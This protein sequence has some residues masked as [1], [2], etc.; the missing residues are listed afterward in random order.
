ME[1]SYEDF[2][3]A[4]PSG[5]T[6]D[7]EVYD[8]V[9][10]YFDSRIFLLRGILTESLFRRIEDPESEAGGNDYNRLVR[11]NLHAVG[12]VC[13]SAYYL[14]IP[15]LDLVLT[16]TGFGVVSNQNVAPASADRVA[17]LRRQVHIDEMNHLDE[18]I[19]LARPVINWPVST[20]DRY[21]FSS[22][23]W[24][25]EQLRI[26]G[27]AEPTR[28]DLA[29]NR[30]A[31]E[32]AARYIGET[33]SPELH[34]ALIK[35]EASA[36]ATVPQATLIAMWRSATADYIRCESGSPSAAHI[37]LRDS[38]RRMLRYVEE[39]LEAFPEYRDS[40]TYQANHFE[41]Y[42]NQKDDSCFFFG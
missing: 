29:E 18:L 1:I 28:A 24:K 6:P 42:E 10:S 30:P 4:C 39:N 35:A 3:G 38:I 12:Y 17:A 16:A 9:S 40:E 19:D 8:A 13:T 22:L 23:F 21:F 2:V 20:H 25:S 41:R 31:I 15:H 37:A 26:L 5:M 33:L 14:A 7:R 11:L 34:E 32:S 27:I 36:S